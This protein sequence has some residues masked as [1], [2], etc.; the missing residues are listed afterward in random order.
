MK[1]GINWTSPHNSEIIKNL[2]ET[3]TVDFCE[4]LIDNFLLYPAEQ[5]QE[6]LPTKESSFHIMNSN[7]IFAEIEHLKSIGQKIRNSI[8]TLIPIYVSDH[9]GLFQYNDKFFPFMQEV[10]YNELFSHFKERLRIWSDIL[11]SKIYLENFCAFELQYPIKQVDFYKRFQD[12]LGDQ[13]NVLF[14]FSNALVAQKNGCETVEEW[15][16]VIQKTEHFHVGGFE[17]AGTTPYYLDSHN[18]CLTQETLDLIKQKR[19]LFQNT[20]TLV[21]ERDFNLIFEEWFS[22]I[23]MVRKIIGNDNVH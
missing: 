3:G 4:I 10:N 7:F 16:P 20:S 23:K 5:I 9:I 18:Q 22:D 8:Q 13:A 17:K 19:S 21:I 14:D 2:C 15:E 12:E 11:E 1:I 6:Y